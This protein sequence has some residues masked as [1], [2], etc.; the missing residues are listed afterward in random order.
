MVWLWLQDE[1]LAQQQR[2]LRIPANFGFFSV[3]GEPING[4]RASSLKLTSALV[5]NR[6]AVERLAFS[7]KY[8][9]HSIRSSFVCWRW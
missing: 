2:H 3:S 7:A 8:T 5:K 4:F 6:S 1:F 9:K